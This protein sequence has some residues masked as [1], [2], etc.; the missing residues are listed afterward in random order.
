MA[1]Y[2]RVHEALAKSEL[3]SPI[4]TIWI[5]LQH[6]NIVDFCLLW[7]QSSRKDEQLPIQPA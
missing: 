1:T 7:M 5:S 3:S 6:K 2:E 4:I